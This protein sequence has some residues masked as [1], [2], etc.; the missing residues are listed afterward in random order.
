MYLKPR[1]SMATVTPHRQVCQ[2][3]RQTDRQRA[4]RQKIA[5]SSPRLDATEAEGVLAAA[6]GNTENA[7]FNRLHKSSKINEK[8]QSFADGPNSPALVLE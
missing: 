1:F 3:Y 7:S 5:G 8:A 2:S 4:E 6:A